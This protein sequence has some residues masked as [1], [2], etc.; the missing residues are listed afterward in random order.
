MPIPSPGT[1]TLVTGV[2]NVHVAEILSDVQDA[3]TSYQ[4]PSVRL[5][6]VTDTIDITD[7]VNQTTYYGD[8]RAAATSQA[9]GVIDITIGKQNMDDAQKA[10]LLG[11]NIEND[12]VEDNFDDQ[13]PFVAL[14]YELSLDNG[15]SK[16][17]QIDKVQFREGTQGGT[18]KTD[19]LEYQ[20]MQMLGQGISRLS[21]GRRK[22]SRIVDPADVASVRALFFG[23]ANDQSAISLTLTTVPVDDATGVVVSDD[24]VLTYNNKMLASTVNNGNIQLFK[25]SDSSKVE[26]TFSIDADQKV[27]TASRDDLEASTAYTLVVSDDVRDIYGQGVA[28]V[29]NFT[30][31]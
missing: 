27:I 18:T 9:K 26:L 2:K 29:I 5:A 17:V 19:T 4:V 3:S 30:T 20:S 11:N 28:R 15:G 25:D 16:F 22:K 8:D 24:I 12:Y 21:D 14:Q 7:N 31:A 1:P 6:G 10:A 13:P 23:N